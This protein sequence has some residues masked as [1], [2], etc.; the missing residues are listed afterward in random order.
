M[1]VLLLKVLK[2]ELRCEERGSASTLSEIRFVH[3][4]FVQSILIDPLLPGLSESL[5]IREMAHAKISNF[6]MVTVL[7]PEEVGRLD[8]AMNDTLMVHCFVFGS[9]KMGAR[10]VRRTTHNIRAP[11]WHL[12]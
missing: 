1:F 9:Q 5:G 10:N 7:C 11:K 3:E 4:N 12:A 6:D 2:Y 8:I